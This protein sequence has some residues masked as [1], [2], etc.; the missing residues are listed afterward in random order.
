MRKVYMIYNSCVYD[1][2]KVDASRSK[3]MNKENM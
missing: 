1:L 2:F 3:I